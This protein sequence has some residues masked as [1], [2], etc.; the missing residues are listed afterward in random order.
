MEKLEGCYLAARNKSNGAAGTAER[1]PLKPSAAARASSSG[2]MDYAA[3]AKAFLEDCRKYIDKKLDEVL[4]PESEQPTTLHKA[5][6]Y[7]VKA[8]GKRLRPA[9]VLAAAEAVG[10]SREDAT[11]AACAVEMI[12]T[13]SL[14][15]DDLPAMDDDDLRR[16][17]PTCH[18][19]FGEAMAILAG[20]ALLT[21][22]FE[23][24]TSTKHTKSVAG[25][26]RA[27]ARGVGTQGM[28][29]GQVLD[30]EGE[31][32]PP[33]LASVC[34]IH[35]WKTAALIT[36][37][38]EAGALAGEAT[39][40]EYEHLTEYGRNIGLAFQIVD[41]ILD[42]TSSPEELGK[43][44][45]KDA[46]VGKATYPAVMGMEKA[47]QEADRLANQ[48]FEALEIFGSRAKTLE[49][50]GRFVIERHS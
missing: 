9:L 4:P 44:P 1:R 26:V 30:I 13:Y 39:Q 31:G 50:L 35:S 14:I 5:M 33:T 27:I 48:A 7:S 28:V 22:S 29:G 46:R 6:R 18:K 24:L 19:V 23:V 36:A 37:C 32:K 38:C 11:P 16:G 17:L 2:Q 43:T 49:A 8:G 42:I 45:G 40:T 12:H 10:G 34:A 3:T 25:I 20:D 21:Y 47:R 41:D 15:H